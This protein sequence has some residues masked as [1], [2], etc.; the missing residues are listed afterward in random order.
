MAREEAGKIAKEVA[1]KISKE[2]AKITATQIAEQEI[3]RISNKVTA[4]ITS[5]REEQHAKQKELHVE[6]EFYE[7]SMDQLILDSKSEAI[8]TAK[9]EFAKEG[10][11]RENL[12]QKSLGASEKAYAE[13]INRLKV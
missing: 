7:A 13:V 5:L 4:S 11:I 2:F 1:I 8:R 6:H 3:E 10:T 9:E 12:F